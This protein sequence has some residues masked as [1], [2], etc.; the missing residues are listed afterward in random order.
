MHSKY[1]YHEGCKPMDCDN[2]PEM[3]LNN[4]WRA[5]MSITG[6]SGLPD[7]S[8][9]GNVVRASTTVKVS[10]RLPPSA[11]PAE[12]EAKLIKLLTDNPP[13]NAKITCKGGHHGQG[14]CMKAMDPWLSTAVKK[15]GADFFDGKDTGS[16]GMG[17]S[18]PFLAELDKMYPTT[19]ILALGLIGPKA[20]A[21]AVNECINLTFAKKLTKAL[22]H[23]IAE[24]AAKE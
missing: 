2:L 3:Y 22:S 9:A 23:L 20:N 10:L 4:T 21:H 5:N 6:A 16:Y 11:K 19:T 15:A 12:T 7:T 13:N 14:W 17:G 1:D 18:I 24:V 8:I